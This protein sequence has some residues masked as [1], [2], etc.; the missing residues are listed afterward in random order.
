M[1]Y[2]APMNVYIEYAFLD[3]FSM[4]CLILYLA[5]SSL[6]LPVKRCRILLGATVGSVTALLTVNIVGAFL[7]VAKT[8]SLLLMCI[9][10]VGF[11]KKLFW[12]ILTTC[13]YTF[14]LGGG[15]VGLF[16]LSQNSFVG[17]VI[18]QSD[19]P[20]FCYFFAILIVFVIAKLLI[21]YAKDVRKIVPN[22]AK[23]QV[24]LDGEFNVT[25]FYDSGNTATCYGLPLCFVGKKFADV[26]AKRLLSG[27]TK[28]VQISTVSGSC[29]V[30]ATQG[31]LILHGVTHDVYFAIAKTSTLYD[32]ILSS[33]ICIDEHTN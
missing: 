23:C 30:V 10:T 20:L 9:A 14:A 13:A 29:T 28:Q 8:L 26:F 18:Y 21:V 24:I 22:L 32:V 16:N 25:A 19:V 4:D 31:K 11:G 33:S 7:Y 17:G 5:T 15:I 1:R 2:N 27:N 6:K 3:N 12:H